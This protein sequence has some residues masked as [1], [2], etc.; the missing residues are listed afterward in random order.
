MALRGRLSSVLAAAAFLPPLFW[1]GP[2]LAGRLAPSFRDQGDFFYPLKLYTAD[3][4][5]AGEIPLWNPLSGAGEPWLAGGQSGVFYPPNAFFLL[6]WPGAA[7]IL[8]LLFHFAVAAWGMRRFLKAEGV[9][10]S[11]ALFGAAAFAASGYSASLS[12]FWNHFGAW[13]YLPAIVWLARFGARTRGA[14][15][16][17]AGLVGLQAMA[18]SPEIL[19]VTVLLALVFSLFP[20]P[21]LDRPWADSRA[22][23]PLRTGGAILLGLALAAWVLVPMGELALHSDRRG[24]LPVAEREPGAAPV[25]VLAAALASPPSAPRTFWIASLFMGSLALALAAAAFFERERRALVIL[26]AAIALAGLLVSAAGPPGSWLRAIPPLDR[27]RYPEKGLSM[28]VFALAAL[29]G[30]G[31]DTIRF[32]GGGKALRI[33][34]P[35]LAAAAILITLLAP[36]PPLVRIASVAGIVFA[37]LLAVGAGRREAAGG[38]LA[39]AAALSLVTTLAAANRPLFAFAPES[40]IRRRPPTHDVLGKLTGRV[41]TPP[42]A[43]LSGWVVRDVTFDAVTLA[44]QREA[45][46]GYTNLLF[47]VSLVRTAAALPTRGARSIA[48]SIDAAADPVRA[49]GPVSARVLWSPFRPG[50]V[51]SRRTGE[52]YRAPIAPYRPRLSFARSYRVEPNA[53]RAWMRSASGEVDVAREVLLD[54]DPSPRP[55]A[56]QRSP[57]LVARLA[58]DRPERVVAEIATNTAGLLV[59][60]DLFYPGWTAEEEGRTLEVLRADGLFRA[61]ALPAGSHRVTFLYRPTSFRI[62]AGISVAALLT[63]L[64]LAYQGEPIRV[65]RPR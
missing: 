27:M 46:T 23:S 15:L 19:A 31:L 14:R 12:A 52:F 48:E 60:T 17:L 53:V 8:F 22:K 36:T 11:G 28:S 6:P 49:A 63:M 44:R 39:A 16:A 4:L 25:T 5:L 38:F 43:A 3:R 1:F 26:L 20:R 13:A 58:E 59:L 32:R 56:G 50:N 33:A 40:E 47:D 24:P 41:L 21:D 57:I 34:F 30:L 9:S 35:A 29:G 45:L 10:D 18:G 61:V 54:R 62:G 64:L 37:V 55:P 7:A 51:P 42:P 65:G 2:A